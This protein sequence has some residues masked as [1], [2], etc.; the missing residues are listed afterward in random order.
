MNPRRCIPAVR[1]RHKRRKPRCL[2]RYDF[3]CMMKSICLSQ[4]IFAC[5]L[6]H[7]HTHTHMH[8]HT[9]TRTHT[10]T[11]THTYTHTNARAHVPAHTHTHTHH[12]QVRWQTK[13]TRAN[14]QTQQPVNAPLGRDA[15]LVTGLGKKETVSALSKPTTFTAGPT[16][17]WARTVSSPFL[18]PEAVFRSSS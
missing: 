8:M 15:V 14:A 5:S 9:H 10:H 3:F 18:S 7:A 13:S 2:C 17:Y 4:N 16:N 12:R 11:H 1:E 6:S